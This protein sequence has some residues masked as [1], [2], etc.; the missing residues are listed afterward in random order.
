MTQNL[1]F[2]SA[3]ISALGVRIKNDWRQIDLELCSHGKMIENIS[4][5][6][7]IEMNDLKIKSKEGLNIDFTEEELRF[8]N[9]AV[10]EKYE[11][12]STY[13]EVYMNSLFINVYALFESNLLRFC[14]EYCNNKYNELEKN[15]KG[16]KKGDTPSQIN[17]LFNVIKETVNLPF[18]EIQSIFELIDDKYRLLRNF[19]AHCRYKCDDKKIEELKVFNDI[20]FID[21][22]YVGSKKVVIE[23]KDFISDFILKISD[24]FKGL[25]II[26]HNKILKDTNL[27]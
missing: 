5:S 21:N 18:I 1:E 3:T 20:K 22:G 2:Q 14:L 23:N 26:F 12:F 9:H 25:Y 7:E 4:S 17:N 10:E 13:K 11:E 8:Y 15:K 27:I 6:I 16:K 19:I 24:F